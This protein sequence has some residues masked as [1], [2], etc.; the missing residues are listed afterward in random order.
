MNDPSDEFD[1]SEE[2]FE[3]NEFVCSP[4]FFD[5]E[6]SWGR[7]SQNGKMIGSRFPS[8]VLNEKSMN[9]RKQTSWHRNVVILYEDQRLVCLSEFPVI[10]SPAYWHLELVGKFNSVR[11]RKKHYI[12][13]GVSF[14]K[15]RLKL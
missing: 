9:G 2:Y 7:G 12:V 3:D 15:V 1:I 6:L 5:D 14:I 8:E 11:I 10:S 4:D 13:H